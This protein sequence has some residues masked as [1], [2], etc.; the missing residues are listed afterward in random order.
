[1]VDLEETVILKDVICYSLIL[2]IVDNLYPNIPEV[3]EG[4]S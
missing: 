2:H 1:M 4:F 3:G